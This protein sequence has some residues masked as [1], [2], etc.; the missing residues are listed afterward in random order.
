MPLDHLPAVDERHDTHLAGALRTEQRIGFPDLLDELASFGRRDA[1]RVV[2]GNVNDLHGLAGD[3]SLLHGTLVPLPPHL[4]GVPAVVADKLEALVGDV[5]GDL[6]DEVAGTEEL[7]VA[8]NLRVETGA[9][10][11]RAL[12]DGPGRGA[13]LYFLD[14]PAHA[15]WPGA[16]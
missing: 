15:S 10:D 1:A 8:L 11:D 4:V 6:R 13:R 2:F 16:R 7:E 14:F 5:L 3:R 12:G 9:V